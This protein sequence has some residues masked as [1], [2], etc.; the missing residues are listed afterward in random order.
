MTER[1]FGIILTATNAN[2]NVEEKRREQMGFECRFEKAMHLCSSD[3]D[4][5]VRDM[6]TEMKERILKL[7]GDLVAEKA[8]HLLAIK[9]KN[10]LQKSAGKGK[11]RADDA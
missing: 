8:A 3:N 4:A 2:L 9:K 11:A 1:M 5:M 6:L 7:D 10:S